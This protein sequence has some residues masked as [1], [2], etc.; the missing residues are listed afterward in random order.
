MLVTLRLLRIWAPVR[1]TDAA[2]VQRMS[3]GYIAR[4]LTFRRSRCRHS[5]LFATRATRW[6]AAINWFSRGRILP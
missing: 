4:S 1:A 2:K 3:G 6:R 5:A